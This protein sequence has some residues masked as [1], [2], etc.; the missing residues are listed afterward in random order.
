M[1]NGWRATAYITKKIEFYFIIFI[2]F[3]FIYYLKNFV[4]ATFGSLQGC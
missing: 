3:I 1:Q 4:L 2:N